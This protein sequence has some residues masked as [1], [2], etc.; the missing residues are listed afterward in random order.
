MLLKQS[1]Q[2]FIVTLTCQKTDVFHWTTKK[3]VPILNSCRLKLWIASV[4][5]SHLP[6]GFLAF[7]SGP[8]ETVQWIPGPEDQWLMDAKFEADKDGRSV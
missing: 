8:P 7:E 2:F 5:L 4:S 3:M 6:G 1:L